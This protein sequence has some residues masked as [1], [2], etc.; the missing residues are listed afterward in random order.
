MEINIGLLMVH[1]NYLAEYVVVKETQSWIK[2]KLV[3]AVMSC[4]SAGLLP[5]VIKT[6]HDVPHNKYADTM[7]NSLL[8][9]Q[10][11]LRYLL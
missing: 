1:N 8:S 6:D 3:L 11:T 7:Y 10:K 4:H 2:D 9:L 5:S